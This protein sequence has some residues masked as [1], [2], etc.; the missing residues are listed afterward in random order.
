MLNAV[1]VLTFRRNPSGGERHD[2]GADVAAARDKR[3]GTRFEELSDGGFLTESGTAQRVGLAGR[4]REPVRPSL[5]NGILRPRRV[6]AWR[7]IGRRDGAGGAH[8]QRRKPA[9]KSHRSILAREGR[10]AG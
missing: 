3:T 8:E 5:A 9:T 10:R 4:G 6:A 1:V 2:V 7:C